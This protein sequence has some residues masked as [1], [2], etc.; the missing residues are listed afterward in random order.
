M[1]SPDETFHIDKKLYD[2]PPFEVPS[3]E[4]RQKNNKKR[5]IKTKVFFISKREHPIKLTRIV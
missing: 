3:T 5:D 1:S 4:S 2:L